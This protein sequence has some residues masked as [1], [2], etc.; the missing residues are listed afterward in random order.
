MP[1]AFLA[2]IDT[3]GDS[4]ADVQMETYLKAL[5]FDEII[6]TLSLPEAELQGFCQ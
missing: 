4:L 5:I 2:G 6:P 3:V 1:V